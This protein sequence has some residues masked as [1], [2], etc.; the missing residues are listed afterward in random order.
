M[1][2]PKAKS[3]KIKYSSTIFFEHFA[4]DNPQG[5][6]ET[7]DEVMIPGIS[8]ITEGPAQS[9]FVTVGEGDDAKDFQLYID[10]TTV[11]QII[12]GAA[13]YENGV[14]V[15]A[16][17]RSGVQDVIGRLTE[18]KLT[19]TAEGKKQAKATLHLFKTSP[20][21]EHMLN[22]VKTIPDAIGFS[23]VFDQTVQRIGDLFFARCKQL[24]SVDLVSEPS[25]NPSGV[26]ETE[27]DNPQKDQGAENLMTP[28]ELSQ[29]CAT[30]IKP[31][32]DAIHARM[33]TMEEAH[34]KLLGHPAL[35]AAATA[36]APNQ[37]T[38]DEAQYSRFLDRVLKE[39]KVTAL[40]TSELQNTAKTLAALGLT[41]GTGPLSSVANPGGPAAPP[42]IEDMTF[43]QIVDLEFS[44]PENAS[45]RDYE[46]IREV[47]LSHKA[48]HRAA[49]EKRE[50]DVMPKR[51]VAFKAA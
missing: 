43:L 35:A 14:K 46:I 17:H 51:K 3:T 29:A 49:L 48:K 33:G 50:L 40:V 11:Q 10:A 31:H 44:K 5:L 4:T 25:T 6:N 30:A 8:V 45:R 21:Y 26:F 15:K 16:N 36:S 12:D 20:L 38:D 27:V 32:M 37:P 19:E 1:G 2:K 42:K 28:E 13:K 41:P 47:A 24:F 39:P 18:F 22:I 23:S 34:K 7:K 9:H